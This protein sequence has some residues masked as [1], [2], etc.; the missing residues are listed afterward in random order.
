MVVAVSLPLL[1]SPAVTAQQTD[2]TADPT[3]VG[4]RLPDPCIGQ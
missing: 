4:S 3:P 1:L 2:P